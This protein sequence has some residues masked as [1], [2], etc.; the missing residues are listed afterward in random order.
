MNEYDEYKKYIEKIGDKGNFYKSWST[1]TE[2]L[3][4]KM[5]TL[6]ENSKKDKVIYIDKLCK[7]FI[8]N[9]KILFPIIDKYFK[10]ISII[11]D[12]NTEIINFKN[13]RDV[14]LYE[15]VDFLYD[16]YK[17]YN[18][19][20][21]KLVQQ[22]V[23]TH[24]NFEDY[25]PKFKNRLFTFRNN[26]GIITDEFVC[27][28]ENKP[29][30]FKPHNYQ[31]HVDI[32]LYI[33]DIQIYVSDIVKGLLKDNTTTKYIINPKVYTKNVSKLLLN[34]LNE[35][36]GSKFI[37]SLHSSV[38]YYT[39]QCT[40][41]ETFDNYYINK[42]LSYC[43]IYIKPIQFNNI[44]DFAKAHSITIYVLEDTK[45]LVGEPCNIDKITIYNTGQPNYIVLL[46]HNIGNHVAGVNESKFYMNILKLDD[47]IFVENS[48]VINLQL[49]P[50]PTPKNIDIESFYNTTEAEGFKTIIDKIK[51]F[52]TSNNKLQIN[53][54]NVDHKDLI[55][56]MLG[57][58]KIPQVPFNNKHSQK[59]DIIILLSR[60]KV[61][62]EI[63]T[64]IFDKLVS[65]LTLYYSAGSGDSKSLVKLL[66]KQVLNV[67]LFILIKEYNTTTPFKVKSF[68]EKIC[69]VKRNGTVE[70]ITI[71]Q[72]PSI[73][74]RDINTDVFRYLGKDYTI[75]IE[76]EL[77]NLFTN[78]LKF[79][80]TPL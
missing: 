68:D 47:L 61:S 20:L 69:A 39:I 10:F 72:T 33:E 2:E 79:N 37:L 11:N 71:D 54:P 46:Y 58:K 77:A 7:S 14:L 1:T 40:Y 52:N 62:V 25:V 8:D 38:T 66:L 9:N 50:P 18:D 42:Y 31:K 56:S 28:D 29:T 63:S 49:R 43:N 41:L 34:N 22:I 19:E 73:M 26:R 51:H 4:E 35:K 36:I 75:T 32:K 67:P 30:M 16:K 13:I 12:Y 3:L 53:I 55:Y 27:L 24:A 59:S 21:E 60:G 17:V 6:I 57:I 78:Y 70:S 5:K 45:S 80:I 23:L 64:I 65:F 44:N 74:L 76:P 48:K 15:F